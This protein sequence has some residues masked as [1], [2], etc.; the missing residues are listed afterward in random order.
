MLEQ[1]FEEYKKELSSLPKN[2]PIAEWEPKINEILKEFQ[3]K[4]G[5]EEPYF[6]VANLFIAQLN[7]TIANTKSPILPNGLNLTYLSRD[8]SGS[9][10]PGYIN[11]MYIVF[12]KIVDP[13]TRQLILMPLLVQNFS[14]PFKINDQMLELIDDLSCAD[15][16]PPFPKH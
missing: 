14:K 16:T 2:L 9:K 13:V 11:Q 1:A 12:D 5:M 3:V 6:T 15:A 7:G 4:V 8:P 10:F